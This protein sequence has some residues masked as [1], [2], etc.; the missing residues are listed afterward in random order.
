MI[1]HANHKPYTIED[2]VLRP[3][4]M[5]NWNFFVSIHT[6]YLEGKVDI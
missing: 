1:D 4:N 3:I 6:Y 2:G 5:S